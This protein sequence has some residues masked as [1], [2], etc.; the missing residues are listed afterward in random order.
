MATRSAAHN[1]TDKLKTVSAV[2]R[3]VVFRTVNTNL[4][5]VVQPVARAKL[6]PTTTIHE[7]EVQA[8]IRVF[9]E[10]PFDEG[11]MRHE[12]EGAQQHG[13]EDPD[14]RDREKNPKAEG[15][16]DDQ[17][18]QRDLGRPAGHASRGGRLLEQPQ[19]HG[20]SLRDRWYDPRAQRDLRPRARSDRRSTGFLR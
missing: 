13:I 8:I 15:E 17:D 18:E 20:V 16:Q 12:K 19:L 2:T 1:D 6:M 11:D 9:L 3:I 7:T 5:V 14:D 10:S 4:G